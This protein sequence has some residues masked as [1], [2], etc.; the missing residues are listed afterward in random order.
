MGASQCKQSSPSLDP[1]GE[2]GP[3]SGERTRIHVRFDGA[4]GRPL[5]VIELEAPAS[6]CGEQLAALRQA[7]IRAGI[8][9]SHM[10][11]SV[12]HGRA[13]QKLWISELDGT[14]VGP[15]RRHAVQHAVLERIGMAP[16]RAKALPATGG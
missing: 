16:P 4:P 6:V 14:V 12:R 9:I 3:P 8:Q 1:H 10:R 2:D 7:L 13:R 11:L 5:S 15:A